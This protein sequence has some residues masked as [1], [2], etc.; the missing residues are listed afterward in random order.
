R[1]RAPFHARS[2]PSFVVPQEIEPMTRKLS[3]LL[4]V[5]ALALAALAAAV[6]ASAQSQAAGGA[7][8]G[9]V[10]DQ[11]GA[12]LPGATVTIRNVNTG[13]TRETATEAGGLYRAPLLP[14]GTYE[15][16][17]ALSGFATTKRPN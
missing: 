14:V 12:V 13:V 9:T 4:A 8:E 10:T 7:I 11:S 6:P 3:C 2:L 16:A 5:L 1:L 15:V 17:V